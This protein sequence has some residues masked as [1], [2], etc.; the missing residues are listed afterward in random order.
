[1][2]EQMVGTREAA[3][4]LGVHENTIYKMAEKGEIPCT[5]IGTRWKFLES[6]LDE[7]RRS[8]LNLAGVLARA[9]ESKSL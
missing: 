6:V 2:S 3:R 5:K 4:F 1:M 8:R 9:G 7:W